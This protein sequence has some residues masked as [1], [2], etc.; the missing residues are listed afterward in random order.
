ME[1]EREEERERTEERRR[2]KKKEGEGEGEGVL[3]L[4][5]S[6]FPSFQTKVRFT[7]YLFL[8]SQ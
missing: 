3:S 1:R 8:D 2:E 6:Q 4:F 5:Y 7:S